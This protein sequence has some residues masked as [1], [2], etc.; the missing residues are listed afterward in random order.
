MVQ[1]KKTYVE[2]L[3]MIGIIVTF[4]IIVFQVT[5]QKTFFMK[6]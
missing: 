4:A 1:I 3:Q 2:Y 5:D 6:N